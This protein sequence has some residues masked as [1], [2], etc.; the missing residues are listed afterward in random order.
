MRF[1]TDI[2]GTHMN[3]PLW[4]IEGMAEYLS[5]GSNDPHTAVWLRDAALNEKLPAVDDLS[6]PNY[7]PYRFG[8][9]FWA[10]VGG[11]WGD[12]A[13]AEIL[14]TAAG[15]RTGPNGGG[16]R[17][18]HGG[19]R[20]GA[21][22]DDEEFSAEWHT[23][24]L[25][26]MLRPLGDRSPEA[27]RRIIEPDDEN[28]LNV[29]P[30]FSPDGS[31][32]AFLSSRG[33][34]SIDLFIADATTGRIQRK[35]ISTAADPH[36]DSLQ[37]ISSAGAWDPSGRRFAVA[38]IRDGLPVIAIFDVER[39]RREREIELKGLDEVFNPAWSPDGRQSRFRASPEGS[40]ISG[41]STWIRG[42]HAS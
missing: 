10:Y 38:A 32:I 6:H 13:I 2:L 8:H 21:G 15:P 34:L 41:C 37:F 1:S 5:I 26:S 31:R 36:F 28:E 14:H 42:A 30:V 12:R 11:R 39:G 3:L 33:R 24:I 7:F 27:G 19:H 9:A 29:G 23:S 22:I 18:S 20:A 16:D 17:R 25:Q 40:A 35:L 4:F